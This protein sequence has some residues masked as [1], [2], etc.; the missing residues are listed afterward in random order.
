MLFCSSARIRD[1]SRLRDLLSGFGQWCPIHWGVLRPLNSLTGT[2][3]ICP[4]EF[5]HNKWRKGRGYSATPHHKLGLLLPQDFSISQTRRWAIHERRR[6]D[7]LRHQTACNDMAMQQRSTATPRAIVRAAVRVA[8]RGN[9][10]LKS[11][12]KQSVA[13]KLITT[14]RR[15]ESLATRAASRRVTLSRGRASGSRSSDKPDLGVERSAWLAL[16]TQS[17]QHS[18]SLSSSTV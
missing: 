11:V 15:R 3:D 17:S 12:L 1:P 9:T 13:R 10:V 2:L 18:A 16:Q 8:F 5:K 7:D 6:F 14:R 4:T